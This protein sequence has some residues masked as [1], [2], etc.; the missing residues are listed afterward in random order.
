MNKIEEIARQLDYARHGEERMQLYRMAYEEADKMN[1]YDNQMNYRMDFIC[2]SILYFDRMEIYIVFPQLLQLHD[3]YLKKHGNNPYTF[4]VMWKYKWILGTAEDFY[5]ISL[6][7]MDQLLEDFRRR[8]LEYGYSLRTY[9]RY[10]YAFFQ[11]IDWG[12]AEEAYHKFLQYDRDNLSDCK[13][14]ELSLEVGYLLATGQ[15][16]QAIKR[17]TV[18]MSRQLQCSEVPEG[19]CG[20]FLRFYNLKLCAGEAVDLETTNRY[21]DLLRNGITKKGICKVYLGDV[22]LFYS[23]TNS[24]KALDWFKKYWEIFETSKDPMCKFYFSLGTL[25]FLEHLKDQKTYKVK[26][27]SE[28]PLYQESGEYQVQK[29]YQYYNSYAVDFARKLDQRNQSSYYMD[30]YDKVVGK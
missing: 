8:C 15:E 26:L 1:D 16:E 18:L 25:K 3:S 9:Y 10:V 13:A 22:L 28:F 6:K 14:C 5:Q 17:A 19:T 20:H 21:C 12:K 27:S 11:Y 29:L 24:A 30:I 23:L 4:D 7:Q 2:E